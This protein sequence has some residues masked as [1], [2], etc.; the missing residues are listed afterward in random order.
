MV[1]QPVAPLVDVVDRTV[2]ALGEIDRELRAL[3]EGTIVRALAASEARKE[4][5]ARRADLL[6][7]LDR[8]R[9]LE[10]RRAQLLGRLLD[11][12]SLLRRSVELGLRTGDADAA[13]RAELGQ[14]LKALE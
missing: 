10:D 12:A 9:E 7:G 2:R 11:A 13:Y 14:A 6:D 3:D 1:T 5:A 8:L 4:P